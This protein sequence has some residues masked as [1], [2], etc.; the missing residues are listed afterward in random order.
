[1]T[2]EYTHE[3]KYKF[4]FGIL[5]S[6]VQ[7]LFDQLIDSVLF[8]VHPLWEVVHFL[9]LKLS[10]C[11]L[12]RTTSLFSNSR[13]RPLSSPESDSHSILLFPQ[14][15]PLCLRILRFCQHSRPFFKPNPIAPT[16]AI[17]CIFNSNFHSHNYYLYCW[18]SLSQG[19]WASNT[20]Q[21]PN[22]QL[23]PT[24]PSPS[25][26]GSLDQ[27]LVPHQACN[28]VVTTTLPKMGPS[29]LLPLFLRH[30]PPIFLEILLGTILL[31]HRI[32]QS[33]IRT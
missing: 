4:G 25:T 16:K 22:E 1:M 32:H 11:V 33:G 30:H 12:L 24:S 19:H 14:A 23:Q 3:L 2:R 10:V 15:R 21:P 6:K 26:T 18:E 8:G 5:A 13:P 27:R 17:A 31:C 7:Y 9:C 20:L 29:P 28:M